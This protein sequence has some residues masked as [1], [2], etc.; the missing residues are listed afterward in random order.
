MKFIGRRHEPC[1][2]IH[3]RRA[4]WWYLASVLVLS[5]GSILSARHY[6][7]GFDWLYTVASALASQKDNPSGSLW[8][9]GALSLAMALLWPYI[10]A[11]KKGL[12]PSPPAF[13]G[14]AIA[15][16]RLGSVCGVLLGLEGIFLRD[17]SAWVNK[18]HEILGILAFLGLYVGVIGFLVPAIIRQQIYVVPVLLVTFPLLAIGITQFWLYL[19]QRDLGWVG[20]NWRQL[21]TPLWFSFAFWQWLAIGFL[22]I[23]LGLLS[24]IC[25][26]ENKTGTSDSPC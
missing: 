1:R 3:Q 7:G 2:N 20:T 16:L 26:E 17:L 24:F 8:F 11:L 22:A 19:A 9:A 10:S 14:F 6:P 12:Y 21:G 25:I 23:G 13:A 5:L 18:G 4:V 15:A